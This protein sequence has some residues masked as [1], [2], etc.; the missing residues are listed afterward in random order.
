MWWGG[1]LAEFYPFYSVPIWTPVGGNQGAG[2]MGLETQG[3]WVKIRK[4]AESNENEIWE[5]GAQKFG[6]GSR[7]QQKIEKWS[8]E[9]EKLSGS[10]RKN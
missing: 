10:K 8:K 3:A 7:E 4:G 6:K 2:R 5:Q 1:H 9:P